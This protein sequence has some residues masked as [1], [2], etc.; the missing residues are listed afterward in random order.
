MTRVGIVGNGVAA[1]TAIRE[2]RKSDESF[3][4]EIFTDERW[5]YYPR[6]NLIDYIAGRRT[7]EDVVQFGYDWYL[8]N[9][10]KVNLA[11]PITKIGTKDLSLETFG[12][13]HGK[14]DRILVAVG[15]HPFVP[16]IQGAEKKGVHVLRTLDDAIDIREAVKGAGREIVVGGGILGVELAAAM[17]QVGGD[18][19]IVTN[20]DTLL[21]LQLDAGASSVLL[22]RLEEMGITV[23]LNFTC[24]Q[25]IGDV[26]VA[27][28]VSSKGDTIEGDLIVV[29]T[30][31]RSNTYLAR[32]SGLAVSKAIAVDN[33]METSAK[34]IYAAG[35][36]MECDGE[37]Y[38]IIPWAVSTSR[39]AARNIVE[40]GSANFAR[41]TPQNTLQVV[42]IDLTSIG[43][44][45]PETPEF[46]SV[47]Q[48]D[49]EQGRYFKAVIKNDKLVGGIAMG[50]RKVSMKLRRL[51]TEEVDVSDQRQTLFEIE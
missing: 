22:H 44:V 15:S 13:S 45:R 50:D 35:D 37:W 41:V 48:I 29:A 19:I 1:T 6:P 32:Q 30:G 33:H 20:V 12:N 11:S 2:I 7:G 5:G 39:I 46:E 3:D 25:V 31:V 18:P 23:L 38:G 4:I 24:N 34:G 47:V 8:K 49:R 28:V 36:C 26:S 16:P 27:G 42:G 40:P 21:P 51:V 9:D 14:F 17:K 10:V 43:I